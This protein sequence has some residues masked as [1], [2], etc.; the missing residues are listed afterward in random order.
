[1]GLANLLPSQGHFGYRWGWSAGFFIY[2]STVIKFIAS[3]TNS[4]PE[5]L[6]LITSLPQSTIEEGRSGVDQLYTQILQ[7]AFSGI[8]P[9][10]SQQYL[11]FRN[12][13]GAILL[14]FD[15]LSIKDLSDLLGCSIQYIQN[16]TRSLHS[17][18]C[19]P[20]SIEEPIQV[21]HKSFPDFLMDPH[22]CEDK[23]LVVE[24]TVYHARILLACLRLME[25]RLRRNICNLDDYT[26]LSEVK[27][28]STHKKAHIGDG[29]EYACKFWTK[30][31]LEIPSSNPHT[32]E[33]L[34]L[35]FMQWMIFSNG[36]IWW[37]MCNLPARVYPHDFSGRSHIRVGKR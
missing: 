32:E 23:K 10:N 33:T 27:V 7:Q 17:L 19:V 31:L 16:I 36:T 26:V 28:S 20:G 8:H 6:S 24:P 13:V 30:H 5:R 2:A 29:L 11:Q 21:F 37:V 3:E 35:G 9:G 15:P 4:L 34:V 12:V 14:L 18:L 1:M 25:K 22:R